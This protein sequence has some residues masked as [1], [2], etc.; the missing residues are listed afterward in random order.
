MNQECIIPYDGFMNDTDPFCCMLCQF[1]YWKKYPIKCM[2]GSSSKYPTLDKIITQQTISEFN[3]IIFQDSNNWI[4]GSYPVA[5]TMNDINK[6]RCNEKFI[7]FISTKIAL[8]KQTVET[9]IKLIN[10]SKMLLNYGCLNFKYD[11][12]KDNY[13]VLECDYLVMFFRIMEE[14]VGCDEI[15]INMSSCFKKNPLKHL[16]AYKCF[17]IDYLKNKELNNYVPLYL[18]QILDIANDPHNTPLGICYKIYEKMCK[19]EIG[20]ERDLKTNK[21]YDKPFYNNFY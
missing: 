9:N 16:F 17:L 15:N 18:T 19:D 6:L 8:T 7:N 5:F 10:V 20:F 12:F 2:S 14:L 21:R 13:E 1:L 3:Y 4:N 11:N